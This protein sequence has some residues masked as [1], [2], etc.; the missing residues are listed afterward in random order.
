MSKSP[1]GGQKVLS[2]LCLI[3][4][5]IFAA[6]GLSNEFRAG[7]LQYSDVTFHLSLLNQ[8]A[9]V[10]ATGGS[11]LDFWY[12][13]SPFGY[14]VFRVYQYFPHIVIFYTSLVSGFSL[15]LSEALA[16]WTIVL[17]ALLPSSLFLTARLFGFSRSA[18]VAA[19]IG[20]VLLAEAEGYGFGLENYTWGTR[21]LVTQLWALV[22]VGPASGYLWRTIRTGHG[23]GWAACAATFAIGCH[24]VAGYI[25]A[26]VLL[27]ASI[28]GVGAARLVF[29]QRLIR[30]CASA[31]GL[32]VLTAHQWLPILEDR[33]LIHRSLFEPEWKFAGRGVDWTL[34]QLLEGNLFDNGRLPIVTSLVAVGFAFAFFG[35]SAPWGG[36]AATISLL[37]WIS[38]LCGYEAWGWLFEGTP[39]LGTM[40]MHRFVVGV[41]L[42]GLLLAGYGAE[43]VLSLSQYP[44]VRV[45]LS[46]ALLAAPVF[47]QLALFERTDERVKLIS[48]QFEADKDVQSLL[49]ALTTRRPG[50]VY[51]GSAR[52]W[53]KQLTVGGYVEVY[54]PLVAQ[55]VPTMG[56]LFHSMAK[57]GDAL[58]AFDPNQESHYQLFGVHT[59]VA[60]SDWSPPSFL[61][62]EARFGR[63]SL[64]RYERGSLAHCRP[65][66]FRGPES[67][68]LYRGSDLRESYVTCAEQ[69]RVS[70]D[71][72]KSQRVVVRAQLVEERL[73]VLGLSYHPGWRA[74]IEERAL[75]VREVAPGFLGIELPAGTHELLLEYRPGQTRSYL[76]ILSCV[77]VLGSLLSGRLLRRAKQPGRQ[78][79]R[80]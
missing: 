41:Q 20:A 9:E 48:K 29:T 76:L 6:W 73:V 2:A 21:G 63:L 13:A 5:G 60:P 39:L 37:L 25:L 55:G 66:S 24:L 23:W 67:A 26:V 40:H 3:L 74:Q 77:I 7:W 51:A 62:E 69:D 50:W 80:P 75:E 45:L 32:L 38:L 18:A 31:F 65:L 8:M 10:H 59:V 79:S 36:R 11:I 17:S 68:A 52:T 78:G 28:S 16:L 15:G 1:E 4:A 61:T 58:F 44:P 54:H 72:W 33:A 49:G 35:R 14:P 46:A 47:G 34:S 30:G 22:A 43:R 70:V 57:S 27:M 64:L 71:E 53:A 12:D 56:M 42:W 19:G